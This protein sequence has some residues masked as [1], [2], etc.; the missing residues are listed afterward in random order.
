[1]P[2][3]A[4]ARR[5]CGLNGNSARR[6]A[7]LVQ[8]WL[9]R[10]RRAPGHRIAAVAAARDSRASARGLLGAGPMLLPAAAAPACSLFLAVNDGGYDADP[11]LAGCA[12]VPA[13][14][15][16]R[17]ALVALPA[18]G[19]PPR[20]ALVG[21]RRC[22][23]PTR[24]G[25]TCRSPGPTR[26][27]TPGTAPTARP[28]TRS[29]SPCSPSGRS[30][31]R[32]ARCSS[33][34]SR[35][36]IGVIALVA[37]LKVARGGR[38]ARPL[39][40]GGRLAWPVSYPNGNVALWFVGFWPCVA[41]AV[42]A[43]GATRRCA[44]SSLA[45]AVV[46]GGAA[47]LGQ[48]RGWLFALPVVVLVFLAVSPA[49]RARSAWALIG[50]GLGDARLRPG[51]RRLR[52][53]RRGEAAR[54]TDRR[55]RSRDPARRARRRRAGGG[56]GAARPPRPAVAAATARR[57]GTA[58]WRSRPARAWSIGAVRSWRAWATR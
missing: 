19:R 26:R 15:A 1:M 41:L 3:S 14:A 43:R 10:V 54:R 30:A 53:G 40:V 52:R 42:A 55:R 49:P 7:V 20:A 45:L 8:P 37:L 48:S 22:S 29:C 9:R 47:L 32:G 27:P 11:R 50:V 35:S 18:G 2:G 33:A 6:T 4:L 57:A 28:S 24:P 31:R 56:R 17:S 34:R 58:C 39:F 5:E 23:P 36:A 16:R 51:A 44:A 46:L 12:P 38:P 21:R 13:R 25:A